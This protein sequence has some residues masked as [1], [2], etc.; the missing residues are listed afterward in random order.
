MSV[1]NS[2]GAS[3]RQADATGEYPDDPEEETVETIRTASPPKCDGKS[4]STE[5]TVRWRGVYRTRRAVRGELILEL[6][7]PAAKGAINHL[8]RVDVEAGGNS[9]TAKNPKLEKQ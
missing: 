1:Q 9:A 7:V 5:I 8:L 4:H 3:P 2:R 6:T